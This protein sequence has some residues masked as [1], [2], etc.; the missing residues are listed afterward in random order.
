MK[1]KIKLIRNLLRPN[2]HHCGTAKESNEDRVNPCLEK[3]SSGWVLSHTNNPRKQHLTNMNV[4][5]DKKIVPLKDDIDNCVKYNIL[6]NTLHTHNFKFWF[7]EDTHFRIV[8]AAL[9]SP[10][11]VCETGVISTVQQC[12]YV[13][14]RSMRFAKK[15]VS[16]C[17][18]VG[19]R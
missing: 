3:S 10:I 4:Y 9:Q 19:L 7:S 6:Y 11:V 15:W 16:F 13:S 2:H 14:F 18:S 8:Y 1:I 5:N 12:K 17:L